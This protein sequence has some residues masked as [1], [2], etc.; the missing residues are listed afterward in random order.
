MAL[1]EFENVTKTFRSG[2]S[3]KLIIGHIQ[4]R[5]HRRDRSLFHALTNV[6]FQVERGESLAIVGR[7][8][9]GKSTLLSLVAGLVDPNEGRVLVNGRVA[10]LLELGS[11]F[12]TDLTGVENL[13]MNASLLGLTRKRT[14]EVYDSIVDF[15]GIGDFINKPLRTYSSGMVVRLAFAVAVHVDPDI[16]IIDEVL[17]VGDSAFRQKCLDKIHEFHNLGKT[18]L[19]VSHAAG[20]LGA[21]CDRALWLDHGQVVAD[22]PLDEIV[23]MYEG[24]VPVSVPEAHS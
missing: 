7:N 24:E 17:G 11:G 4:D 12:H 19:F 13:W 23:P 15:A 9:A 14:A 6:S 8:G 20:S 3:A 16:L 10:A 18:L 2:T 5:L 22:G 1:I 21:F